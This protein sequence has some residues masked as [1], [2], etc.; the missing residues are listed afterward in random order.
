MHHHSIRADVA[1][2]GFSEPSG[3]VHRLLYLASRGL[4]S[5]LIAEGRKEKGRL[6]ALGQNGLC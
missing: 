2:N 6:S 1:C 4:F 3:S 5:I